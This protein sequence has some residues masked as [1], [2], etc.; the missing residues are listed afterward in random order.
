MNYK[1]ALIFLELPETATDK[2][3]KKR[4]DEKQ[5]FFERMSEQAPSAFLRRLNTQHLTK[6]M[7]I[8]KEGILLQQ[9]IIII[10]KKEETE[11]NEQA[12]PTMPVILPS[13]LKASFKK[14]PVNEPL[15][16]LVRHTE[17][18]S[19][20]P[21]PLFSGKNYIGRK[22]H[23]SLKPF[24][25]LE[26]DEYVSRVHA[27]IYIDEKES[28]ECFIDDSAV[29]NEGKPSKN[30]TFLNGNK[31]RITSKF[32]IKEN[33]AIQIGETKLIIRINSKHIN[34]IVEEVE[35]RDYMNTVII[36]R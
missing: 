30:G 26:D 18:Q 12:L 29:S 35:D 34:K 7:L 23:P 4:L 2:Q 19:V 1:E 31:Q 32:P 10:D 17:N 22:P 28:V 9:P 21:F 27:V 8:R 11:L 25:A 24:I 20:K 14:K 33:D 16:F 15:A 36:R 3:I 13:A 6:V 5:A